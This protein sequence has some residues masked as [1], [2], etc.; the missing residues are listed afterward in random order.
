MQ[1]RDGRERLDVLLKD[2]ENM[3]SRMPEAQRFDVG[4]LRRALGL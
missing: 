3:E 1:T 2:L 4:I